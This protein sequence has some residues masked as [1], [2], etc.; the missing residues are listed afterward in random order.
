MNDRKASQKEEIQQ[1]LI[2]ADYIV[3]TREEPHRESTYSG[4]KARCSA[5]VRVTSHEKY[6]L[7]ISL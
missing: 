1:C 4:K 2:G 6:G 7:L 5:G 3:F